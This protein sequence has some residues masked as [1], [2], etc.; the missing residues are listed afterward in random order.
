MNIDHVYRVDHLVRLGETMQTQQRSLQ[1][2][3]ELFARFDISG[4]LIDGGPHGTGHIHDTYRVEVDADGASPSYVLQRVN[5]NIFKNID[6]LMDNICRVTDH[7]RG[8]LLR[9]NGHDP[10]RECLTVIRS[11]DDAP[12]IEVNDEIWRLYVEISGSRTFDR[13]RNV[14]HA[15]EAA[16]M[17]AS[18]ATLLADLPDPPLHETIPNFHDTP[19][20]VAQLK[21]AIESDSCGRAESCREEIDFALGLES[22][23]DTITSGLRNGS[24]PMRVT[25]NDTKFNNVMIDDQTGKGICVLDLDTV[26]HGSALYD[27][28][29]MVRSMSGEFEENEE[30]QSGVALDLDRYEQI[31]KGYL[32]IAHDV[33]VDREVELLPFSAKLITYEIGIRFLKDYLDG[34]VYFKIGRPHENLDRARTQFALVRSIIEKEDAM[35]AVTARHMG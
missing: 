23:T 18:F 34:D 11:N 21:G 8:H 3:A 26:M 32:D 24:I 30:D 28:G 16:S 4:R 29:D 17:F 10:L 20:R 19:Q 25:H 9:M 7:I 1:E 31:V 22:M 15:Y 12:Y 6:H 27:F 13:V 33:L 5:R 14:N 2:L 35:A